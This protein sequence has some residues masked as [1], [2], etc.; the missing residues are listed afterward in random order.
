REALPESLRKQLD[1]LDHAEQV[2]RL[3]DYR[4]RE[5][6]THRDWQLARRQWDALKGQKKPWPFS[7]PVLTQQ[8]E[9]FVTQSLKPRLLRFEIE[10]LDRLQADFKAESAA[11][12]PENKP[13]SSI[14]Y[15]IFL[16]KMTENHP[17]LPEFGDPKK[18]IRNRE[19]LTT[20]QLRPFNNTRDLKRKLI[21]V[22][23]R[24][25]DL[26]EA[27]AREAK[28][29]GVTITP[30]LGPSRAKEYTEPVAQSLERLIRVLS[31]ED[32]QKLQKLEGQ[33]PEHSRQMM[34]LAQQHDM[35]IPG[36]QLPGSPRE[37]QKYYRPLRSDRK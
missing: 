12:N 32:F 22:P 37:W 19:D 29:A 25:P 9:D 21:D 18:V 26:A 5:K 8:I 3:E 13:F 6:E 34:L 4:R 10:Q 33:W 31:P 23:A 28:K 7:E 36:V 14:R 11:N 1:L 2:Q 35:V 15:A 30:A 27:V 17:L 16:L 24:W 20:E